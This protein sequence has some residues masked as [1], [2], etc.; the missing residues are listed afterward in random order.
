MRLFKFVNNYAG[1]GSA[2]AFAA[3]V[4]QSEHRQF[5]RGVAR[6]ARSTDAPP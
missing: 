4:A 2:Y 1:A 6:S 3:G 5:I